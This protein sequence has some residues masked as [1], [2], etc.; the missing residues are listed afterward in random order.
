[1]SHPKVCPCP[2]CQGES[3]IAAVVLAVAVI[4]VAAVVEL[5]VWLAIAAAVFIV[6]AAGLAWL[7][8]RSARLSVAVW[9]GEHA[10][11]ALAQAK[12]VRAVEAATA[13]RAIEAPGPVLN[14]IVISEE[15]RYGR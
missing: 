7:A 9:R 12:P 15:A 14:G 11:L 1:M 5:A 8:R 4:V 13:P 3:G 10:P 2:N 6:A